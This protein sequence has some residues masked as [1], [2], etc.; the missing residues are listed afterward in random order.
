ML[1]RSNAGT[2][3]GRVAIGA[4]SHLTVRQNTALSTEKVIQPS[5]KLSSKNVLNTAAERNVPANQLSER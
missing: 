5:E 1:F 4:A 3:V 2:V